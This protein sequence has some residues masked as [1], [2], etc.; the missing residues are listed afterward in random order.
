ML[1]PHPSTTKTKIVE[2]S[3]YDKLSTAQVLQRTARLADRGFIKN[4][5][6]IGFDDDDNF[7]YQ[8]DTDLTIAET[9]FLAELIK[10]EALSSDG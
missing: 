4:V 3:G 1:T 5:L 7:F 8:M 2:L 6:I 9:V 10:F